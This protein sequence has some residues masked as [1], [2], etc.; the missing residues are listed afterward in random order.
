MLLL[1]CIN[2]KYYIDFL[3]HSPEDPFF[4]FNFSVLFYSLGLLL[5]ITFRTGSFELENSQQKSNHSGV[6]T[7]KL[8]HLILIG[9]SLTAQSVKNL[10]AMQETGVQSLDGED[11]VEEEVATHSSILAWEIPLTEEP[12]GLQFTG[13]QRVRQD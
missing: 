4:F 9:T 2:R 10:P 7:L 12:G 6:L 5:C 13:L 11:P 3:A 8:C 1:K